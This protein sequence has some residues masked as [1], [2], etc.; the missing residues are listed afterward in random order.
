[1]ADLSLAVNL[2]R[3]HVY[4]GNALEKFPLIKGINEKITAHPKIAAYKATRPITL[5]WI[6]L[7]S[8]YIIIYLFIVKCDLISRKG[9]Y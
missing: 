2:D 8:M 5:I 1:M 3:H 4:I 6:N 9:S 7:D